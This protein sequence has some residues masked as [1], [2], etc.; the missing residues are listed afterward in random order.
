MH[1]LIHAI[2]FQGGVE[3]VLHVLLA[4]SHIQVQRLRTLPQALHVAVEE[5]NDTVVGAQPFPNA[6][7]EDK[8]AV[9]H[10]DNRLVAGKQL[11]VDIDENLVVARILAEAVGAILAHG[12]DLRPVN[13]GA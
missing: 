12:A 5:G 11:A 8:A 6:I 1:I 10:R 9:E 7:T 2:G 4:H 3:P 13:K